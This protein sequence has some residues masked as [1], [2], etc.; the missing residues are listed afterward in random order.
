M[1]GKKTE[2]ILKYKNRGKR[3]WQHMGTLK[4][5]DK[6]NKKEIILYSKDGLKIKEKDV[7]NELEVKWNNFFRNKEN[8]SKEE[9][10]EEERNQ[11]LISSKVDKKETMKVSYVGNQW[12]WTE[13]KRYH[14]KIRDHPIPNKP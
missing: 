10:N 4:G 3:I 13:E 11:Y 14:R 7:G 2:A 8:R 9:W 6:N 1:K 12:H 5:D